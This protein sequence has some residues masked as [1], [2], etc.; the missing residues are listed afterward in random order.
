M[1]DVT[2]GQPVL[3]TE[4]LSDIP[5]VNGEL[6]LVVTKGS[7]HAG[8]LAVLQREIDPLPINTFKVEDAQGVWA[9]SVRAPKSDNQ[10]GKPTNGC[11]RQR[12]AHIRF[13]RY[14]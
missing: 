7:G 9:V 3:P 14:L 1:K 11:I 13:R 4:E 12:K 2:L 8:G 5:P 10:P 6:E